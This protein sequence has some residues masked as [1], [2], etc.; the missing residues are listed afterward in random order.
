MQARP[1]VI[2]HRGASGYLPE[3]SLVAKALAVGMGADY[4]EQD[5]VATRDGALIVFHDLTLDATTD[6]RVRFPGRA[7]PDGLH[8]CVD[9]DLAELRLL[10]AG[11]RRAAGD[12]PR[13]PGRFPADA[14][15]FP[16]VTLEE[17][18]RFID[19]LRRSTGRPLGIY[20]EIKEP[21][22]HRRH[23][24]ELGDRLLETLRSFGYERPDGRAF[25]QCFDAAELRR[26][27]L[28]RQCNLPLV[29]LLERAG[30]IPSP[31]TL[32]AIAAYADAIGP[33]LGLVLQ[34][35]PGG[36]AGVTRLVPDAH[37]AGL[38]VHPYTLRRD[39]LPS[40]VPEFGELLELV[41]TQAG[42]DG[43]FTDFP[44]V[45]AAF[46]DRRAAGPG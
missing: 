28:E 18:L 40:G 31:A 12:V 9:F 20:P 8:Y 11:E 30:G 25:V 35:G 26:L 22:W 29:Q 2:A 45:V 6:V 19:G 21:A 23:G 5:V 3:H 38:A 27:R 24:I 33:S 13:Y 36:R 34:A 46:L 37:A 39:E 4:L 44:D 32:A 15:G 41:F 1:V 43:A 10:S 17:E 14:G 7:R 42:A 16:I